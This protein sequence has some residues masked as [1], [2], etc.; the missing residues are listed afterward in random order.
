MPSSEDSVNQLQMFEQQ[1]QVQEQLI[2][3]DENVNK[4]IYLISTLF[5]FRLLLFY[6][7]HH[8]S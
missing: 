4:C 6:A 8:D 1:Q 7:H 2:W 3:E 5:P